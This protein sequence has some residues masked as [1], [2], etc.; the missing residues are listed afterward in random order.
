MPLEVPAIITHKAGEKDTADLQNITFSERA[1]EIIVT[2][3]SFSTIIVLLGSLGGQY[4]V[5]E[6]T[7]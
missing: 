7:T 5:D 3:M 2:Y 4:K 6:K 1:F